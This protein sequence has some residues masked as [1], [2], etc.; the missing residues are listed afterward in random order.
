MRYKLFANLLLLLHVLVVI[1]VLVGWYYPSL[2]MIHLII[3]FLVL[4]A[5][6]FLGYCPLTRWEFL[7]RKKVEPNLN[8]DSS[9]LSYYA[10]KVLK[11][12]IP[13]RVIRYP[14]I[15]VLVLVLSF[16]LFR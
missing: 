15:L 13:G 5:E 14:A 1:I 9:F 3:A 12:D 7:L 4:I 11:V 2:Q 10:Y 16:N 6:V 8:Y